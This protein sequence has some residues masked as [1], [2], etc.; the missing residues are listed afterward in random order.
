MSRFSQAPIQTAL[1]ASHVRLL[2]FAKLEFGTGTSR[3]HNGIGSYTWNDGT[4]SAEWFGLGE[5]GG[6]SAI[7]EG[8][9]VSAYGVTLTLSALPQFELATDQSVAEEALN[10]NYY[11]KPVTLYVGILDSDDGFLESGGTTYYPTEVWSGFMDSMTVQ[12]GTDQGDSITL[13]CESHLAQFER[14]RGLLY[15]N[16]WQQS[17]LDEAFDGDLFFS[18]MQDIEG[19][20]YQWRGPNKTGVSGFDA[21][22]TN[23]TRQGRGRNN[24]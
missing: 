19:A 6:V 4:G 17:R 23:P 15:T 1:S 14:N 5:F 21:G 7:E 8:R 24:R 18:H 20:K 2:V 9:D 10:Q 22:S 3:I 12:V 11:M 13:V 16:A